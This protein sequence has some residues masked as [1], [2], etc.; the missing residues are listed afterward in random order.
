M[1]YP[2][3]RDE[4]AAYWHL[5]LQEPDVSA[6]EI[7]AALEWQEDPQNRAALDKVAA[8]WNA[9]PARAGAPQ[10]MR[11]PP[12]SR[13]AS[14]SSLAW[15]W[16]FAAAACVAAGIVALGALIY[17][18]RDAAMIS[19]QEYTTP[20]GQID[21]VVLADGTQVMLGGATSIHVRYAG[22]IRHVQLSSGEAMFDVTK[23]AQRPFIVEMPNGSVRVRGTRFNV[24]RGPDSA[25][26]TVLE[27]SVRVTPPEWREG[28]PVELAARQQISL[29]TDGALGPVS[30]VNEAD[31]G[32]WRAGR[33]MFAEQSL[34][35]VVADLNRYSQQ[36]VLIGDPALAEIRISGTAKI[37]Q[38][39]AWLDALGTML[40][41]RVI[42]DD[43]GVTLDSSSR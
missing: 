24:H 18:T 19:V 35:S 17:P 25:T 29:G 13:L 20:V 5:K 43:H 39:D 37:G 14:L 33:L 42:R 32:S 22:D 36:P 6:E 28:A 41:V 7:Q 34:R 38:F 15:R 1:N 16:R 3:A 31:V 30:P 8:F 27:G 12:R 11:G 21:T 4:Q 26:V 23:D 9:W 2:T 40:D 10:G